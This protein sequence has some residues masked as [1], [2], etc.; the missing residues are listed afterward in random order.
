L[1]TC[2]LP[3]VAAN[4]RLVYSSSGGPVCPK[5][6]WPTDACRCST[7]TSFDEAVPAVVV[8][9]LRIE[10]KGRGGKTVTVVDGLPRNANFVAEL[11]R[12]LKKAC[13]TGG[14][15]RDGAIELQGDRREQLRK[16]LATRGV[17]V[18]G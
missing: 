6:G 11:A 1:A 2:I 15:V 9:R 13:A 14:A 7:N 18:K 4:S 12:D 8:A 3:R 10:S 16:I 17:R 5:C